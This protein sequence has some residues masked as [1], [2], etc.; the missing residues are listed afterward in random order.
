MSR[1]VW[2]VHVQPLECVKDLVVC[3]VKKGGFQIFRKHSLLSLVFFCKRRVPALRKLPGGRRASGQNLA[4][5]VAL[6]L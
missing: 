5:P 3:D 1:P 4:N 2:T 6:L